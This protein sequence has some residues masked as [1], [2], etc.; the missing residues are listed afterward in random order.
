MTTKSKDIFNKLLI[1]QD[2]SVDDCYSI[3]KVDDLFFVGTSPDGYPSFL[4]VG[5]NND[6]DLQPIKALSGIKVNFGQDCQVITDEI[7]STGIFNIIS[8][9]EES[10]E[11]RDFFFSFFEDYFYSDKDIN[12]QNLKSQIENL[13]K[14][15]SYKKNKSTKSIMGLWSE[16]FVIATSNNPEVW[17]DK[18]HDQPRSTFDF[19]YSRIGIDVKSFGSH[20]RE[21]YFKLEQLNN[22]S[23]EQTLV[24]SLCIQ[25]NEDGQNVFDILSM[26]KNRI[27]SKALIKKIEKQ[28]FK[29]AGK[30]ITDSKR[31]NFDIA[32]SSMLI[33]KGIDIP[34]IDSDLIPAL[35]SDVKFKV[36]CNSIKGIAFDDEN[37]D[38][39][40]NNMLL[41]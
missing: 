27:K 34:S 24:L 32:K 22:L 28:V 9:T 25:E 11:L 3:E 17:A 2:E 7:K 31:F 18:W 30:D 1:N 40:T 29:L 21:H 37:Q 41:D 26:I 4:V 20:S 33:L 8:C 13:S 14:L 39:I 6:F 36:N 38:K 35:V 19:T 12:A 23:V 16:L 5:T 10:I 15:F